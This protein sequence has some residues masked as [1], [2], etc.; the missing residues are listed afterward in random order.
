MQVLCGSLPP[1]DVKGYIMRTLRNILTNEVVI[2]VGRRKNGAVAMLF[3][4]DS[5]AWFDAD[6]LKYFEEV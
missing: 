5:I 3:D 6:L 2:T 1:L 4:D